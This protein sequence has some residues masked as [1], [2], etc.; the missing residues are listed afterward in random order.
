MTAFLQRG[1]PV[2]SIDTKK[3][4][5][6]AA[7]RNPGCTWRR[8][9]QAQRVLGHDFPQLA[10]GK[11]IPYGAYDVAQDEAL[12][13]VGITHDTA[14]FAVESI[15]RWR[16]LLGT[17][18]YPAARR[19]LIS[20]DAGGRNGNRLRAWKLPA[21]AGRRTLPADHG[22]PL[23]PRNEQMEQDR[24]SLVLVHQPELARA[25]LGQL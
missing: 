20:A 7:F 11:A 5:L 9:G 13:N 14:E 25:A 19:L 21:A 4:E 16:R 2:I 18:T 12:V 3:K 22:V 10:T 6:I 23:S 15:R 1:D 24:A 17:R 8:H